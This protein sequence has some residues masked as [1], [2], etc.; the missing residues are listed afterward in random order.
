MA[1]ARSSSDLKFLTEFFTNKFEWKVRKR[2]KKKFKK[3]LIQAYSPKL[4]V[5]YK[6]LL[7]ERTHVKLFVS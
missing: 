4:E 1:G 2:F 3:K 7:L 6:L 5:P